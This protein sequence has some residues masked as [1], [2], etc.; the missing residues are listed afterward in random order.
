MN[1]EMDAV[2]LLSPE[3]HIIDCLMADFERRRYRKSYLV[4]TSGELHMMALCPFQY[5]TLR[6]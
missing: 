6:P 3:P 4:W 1:P 5:R 2:Y